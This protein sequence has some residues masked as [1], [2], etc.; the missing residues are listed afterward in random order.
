MQAGKACP[1]AFKT[2]TSSIGLEDNLGTPNNPELDNPKIGYDLAG[3]RAEL[4]AVGSGGEGNA[5]CRS[6]HQFDCVGFQN[7]WGHRPRSV[8]LS[9]ALKQAQHTLRVRRL[10]AELRNV[11]LTAPQ[12]SVV[13]SLAVETGTFNALLARRAFI[14]PQ[15]MQEIITKHERA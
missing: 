5:R 3:A 10:D 6:E 7:K 15:T 14:T 11:G 2:A 13:A 9:Y 4:P 1:L 12:Y 8:S